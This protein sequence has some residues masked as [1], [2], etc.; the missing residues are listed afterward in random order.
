MFRPLDNSLESVKMKLELL[1]MGSVKD[2]K[3][4]DSM[5]L[6]EEGHRRSFIP[7]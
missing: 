6:D 5:L 7:L 4:F 2:E 1:S 3:V